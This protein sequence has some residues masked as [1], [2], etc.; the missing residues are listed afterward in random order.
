MHKGI[1]GKDKARGKAS[2]RKKEQEES[3][4][5]MDMSGKR[6]LLDYDDHDLDYEDF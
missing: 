2:K 4:S 1:S 3:G 6:D 5:D